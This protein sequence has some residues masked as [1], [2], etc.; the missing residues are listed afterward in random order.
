MKKIFMENEVVKNL[1]EKAGLFSSDNS[2]QVTFVYGCNVNATAFLNTMSVVSGTEQFTCTFTTP[3]PKDYEVSYADEE[4]KVIVPYLTETFKVSDFLNI[5]GLLSGLGEMLY[6]KKMEDGLIKVGAKDN[7]VELPLEPLAD[8]QKAM[9]IVVDRSKSMVNVNFAVPEFL[10][11]LRIGGCMVHKD[12]DEQRG[13]G[14]VLLSMEFEGKENAAVNG[15]IKVYSSNGNCLS[16]GECAAIFREDGISHKNLAEFLVANQMPNF[17]V[18]VPKKSQMKFLR[19]LKGVEK[20]SVI[21]SDKHICALLDQG[22]MFTFVT[23]ANINSVSAVAKII[24]EIQGKEKGVKVTCDNEGIKGKVDILNN[25][26]KAKK[27][28]NA[29]LLTI[30]D[31]LLTMEISEKKGMGTVKVALGSS[32]VETGSKVKVYLDGD[33]LASAIASIKKGNITISTEKAD[34]Y[35]KAP[36]QFTTGDDDATSKEVVLLAPMSGPKVK[37]EEGNETEALEEA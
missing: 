30:T 18:G 11:A 7:T 3:I 35:I 19:L 2:A 33:Y 37:T 27:C 28:K 25:V 6:L 31:K 23:G 24:D 32:S 29:L 8:D 22:A 10:E 9:P 14:N 34:D 20:C 21:A 36:V 12:S 5:V 16:R 1:V 13:L 4:K 15:R 17:K 26:A